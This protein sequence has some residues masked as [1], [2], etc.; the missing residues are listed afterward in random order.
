[1]FRYLN[2]I[3]KSRIIARAMDIN[4]IL[5]KTDSISKDDI[6]NIE[7]IHEVLTN[8]ECRKN[9]AGTIITAKIVPNDNFHKIIKDNKNKTISESVMFEKEEVKYNIFRREICLGALSYILTN[10]QLLIGSSI[11]DGEYIKD[12][13]LDIRIIGTEDSELIISR[14]NAQ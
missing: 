8:G 14:I 5:P 11:K 4:F 7:L 12:N 13:I 9:G 2:L 3:Q 10:S 1:M 6:D